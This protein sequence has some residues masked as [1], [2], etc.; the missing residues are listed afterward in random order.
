MKNRD[1]LARDLWKTKEGFKRMKKDPSMKRHLD[2]AEDAGFKDWGHAQMNL[3]KEACH[4]Y[5]YTM[6]HYLVW[7]MLLQTGSIVAL[8]ASL[9]WVTL[10]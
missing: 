1:G 2:R 10:A 6:A 9:A 5:P 4:K 7:T 8:I 3:V